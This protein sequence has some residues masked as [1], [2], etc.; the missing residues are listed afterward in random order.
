[1]QTCKMNI[2]SKNGDSC[3]ECTNCKYRFATDYADNPYEE[4]VRIATGKYDYCPKCGAKYIGCQVEGIDLEKCDR[5]TK[6][7]VQRGTTKV[8]LI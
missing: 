6:D 2:V 8:L 7:W 5:K 3:P 4:M 1:M